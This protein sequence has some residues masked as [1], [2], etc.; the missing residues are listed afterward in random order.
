MSAVLWRGL[1][2]LAVAGVAAAAVVVV[3]VPAAAAAPFDVTNTN[4]SGPGSFRQ[5][6]LD[7]NL[8][9]GADTITF[10]VEGT[11]QL[12]GGTIIVAGTLA[13]EGP[14]ADRVTLRG[15][16]TSGFLQTQPT[17]NLSVAGLTFA[18]GSNPGGGGG[19]I[20]NNGGTVAVEDVAFL[21]NSASYGGAIESSN[22]GT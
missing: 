14:G 2:R 11:I 22:I 15:N 17:T 21:R 13:I 19:V 6:V 16:A 8:A 9:P 1:L 10:S 7:A 20:T 12:T 3:V 4:N 5:A 18:D